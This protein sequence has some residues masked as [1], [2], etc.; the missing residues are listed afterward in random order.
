MGSLNDYFSGAIAQQIERGNTLLVSIPKSNALPRELYTLAQTC[1]TKLKGYLQS[2]YQLINAPEMEQ[3]K[4]QPERLREY[5]RIVNS[6]SHL[7]TIGFTVLTRFHD[8]DIFLNR[9]VE[10]ICREIHYPFI[11]PVISSLS[12]GYYYIYC[13]LNLLFVPLGESDFL[14]HLPDLYHELAHPLLVKGDDLR[15][16][17]F[18]DSFY[19]AYGAIIQY[20]SDEQQ[21]EKRRQSRGSSHLS[22][23]MK[24]WEESWGDWLIEFFCDVFATCTVGPAFVW[25]HLHLY[26]KMG[27]NPFYTPTVTTTTHP[28]DDARMKVMLRCLDMLGFKD[29]A[30]KIE[31]RW[32][33]LLS[34]SRTNAEPEYYLCYPDKLLLVI[35]KEAVHGV[36]KMDCNLVT[37][38]NLGNISLLLKNAWNNFWSDSADYIVWERDAIKELQMICSFHPNPI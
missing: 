3:T 25:S 20:L 27:E 28:S 5:R 23:T 21:K 37:P 35:V 33:Q 32:K 13:D 7:E 18:R 4:Y 17:P 31:G 16:A 11:P 22:F 1:E 8:K 10:S 12:Q 2:L 6:M 19:K 15:V 14:L 9:L 34:I 29:D 38:A 26:A 30:K 24:R 36:K